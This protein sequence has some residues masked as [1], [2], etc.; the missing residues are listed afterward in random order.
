MK[1][2]GLKFRVTVDGPQE[3]P[4]SGPVAI[5]GF[6]ALCWWFISNMPHADLWYHGLAS[7][8]AKTSVPWISATA[9]TR[10]ALSVRRNT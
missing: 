7:S 2:A 4:T 6:R 10:R 3:T 5:F 8:G 9:T 1:G